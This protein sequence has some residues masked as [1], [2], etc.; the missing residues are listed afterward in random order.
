MDNRA[1]F[2]QWHSKQI[3]IFVHLCV[4]VECEKYNAKM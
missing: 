1:A 4:A 3:V 2:D